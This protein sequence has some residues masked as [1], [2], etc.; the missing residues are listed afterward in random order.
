MYMKL[1]WNER[2]EFSN[3]HL[4]IVRVFSRFQ[5]ELVWTYQGLSISLVASSFGLS[6]I[7]G[8]DDFHLSSSDP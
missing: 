5:A 4:C 8:S 6:S 7:A 1:Q 2:L 3:K